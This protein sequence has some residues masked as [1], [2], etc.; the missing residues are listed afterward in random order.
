MMK[1]QYPPKI[2]KDGVTCGD[3][4]LVLQ[5]RENYAGGGP[6]EAAS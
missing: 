6:K 3:C 1:I 2:E 4:K 5:T